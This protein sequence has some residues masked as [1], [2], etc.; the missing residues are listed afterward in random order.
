MTARFLLN[1]ALAL[2][3]GGLVACTGDD[4]GK[5]DDDDDTTGDDDDDDDDDNGNPDSGDTGLPELIPDKITMWS[6]FTVEGGNV[7]PSVADGANTY[8]T[9]LV[10]NIGP[11]EWDPNNSADY[12]YCSIVAPMV[13]NEQGLLD[14]ENVVAPYVDAGAAPTAESDCY[15]YFT[16]PVGF[17]P[18]IFVTGYPGWSL[19]IPSAL[20]ADMQTDLDLIDPAYQDLFMGAFWN[21]PIIDPPVHESIYGVGNAVSGG[22]VDGELL[23]SDVTGQS[24]LPDGIYYSDALIIIGFQ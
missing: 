21:I 9:I 19:G 10:V 7:S 12:N 23:R 20:S 14:A 17:D 1:L 13:A 15:D 22:S 11:A 3:I 5:G 16:L 18:T 8:N 24:E 4:T 6:Q 2:G